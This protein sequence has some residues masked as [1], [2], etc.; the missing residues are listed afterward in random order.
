MTLQAKDVHAPAAGAKLPGR[1]RRAR[2]I[3]IAPVAEV[4]TSPL[5]FRLLRCRVLAASLSGHM[6]DLRADHT[7]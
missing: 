4:L 2:L 6:L 3:L 5:V 1:A 7:P